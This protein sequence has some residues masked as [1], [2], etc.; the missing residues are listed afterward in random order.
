MG[1]PERWR[2]LSWMVAAAS[3][4]LAGLLSIPAVRY[5]LETRASQAPEMRL[6]IVTPPTPAPLEFALSPD[7][8]YIVFVAFSDGRRTLWLRTL[9]KTDARP[10]PGTE[11]A[12]F[13]FWSADSR[14]I[15][16]FASSK[17]YRIDI[18]GGPPQVLANAVSARGG[19][20]N[21]AGVILFAP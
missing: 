15:G 20:W 19:A 10:I 21:A 9:N 17:L 14:S 18:A 5:L 1:A 13:P 4:V 11:G 8:R 2:G 16:F 6:Q 7:G 12:E 3:V